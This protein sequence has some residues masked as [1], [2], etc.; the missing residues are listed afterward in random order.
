MKGPSPPRPSFSPPHPHPPQHLCP[1][2]HPTLNLSHPETAQP[3]THFPP[4][5]GTGVLVALVLSVLGVDDDTIAADFQLTELGLADIK[6]AIVSKLTKEPH[7]GG[8]RAKAERMV[9]AS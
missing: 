2:H 4:T 8:D 1:P 3:L 7:L 5:Q 9:T 6:A